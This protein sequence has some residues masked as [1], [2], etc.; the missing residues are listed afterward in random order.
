MGVLLDSRLKNLIFPIYTYNG[1]VPDLAE[2]LEP[3]LNEK[4]KDF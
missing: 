4:L 1:S 2:A 3:V